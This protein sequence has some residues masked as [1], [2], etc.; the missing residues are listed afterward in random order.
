MTRKDYRINAHGINVA[1]LKA[2]QWITVRWDDTGDERCLLLEIDKRP[3]SYKGERDL[4]VLCGPDIDDS[5]YIQT[6]A[7]HMQ[8][9]AIHG[10]LSTKPL[11]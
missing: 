11:K 4:K 1:D 5:W 8:V 10:L 2:G 3:A 6:R 7:V 9:V